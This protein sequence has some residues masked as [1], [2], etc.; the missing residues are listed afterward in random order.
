MDGVADIEEITAEWLSAVLD[1]DVRSVA[2]EAIGT[3]QT[4]ATYRLTLDAD[5]LPPAIV[6]KVAAGDDVAR[7]RVAVGYR[8]EVG[9]YA[10]LLGTVDVR[11]PR[12]WHA[13]V[14]DDATRFTLLLEDLAPRVSGIQ[15]DGCPD[16]R[17][18]D[19]VRNA[20]AL[21]A[22][23]WNDASL[24]DLDF[25]TGPSPE[26]AAFLG[27]VATSATEEFVERYARELA[28]GDKAT[29]RDAAAAMADWGVARQEPF[30]LLHGDY[31][32]DNLMFGADDVV[33]V[34]WQTLAVGPPL[35][36]VAYFLGTSLA[37]DERRRL[38]EDLVGSYHDELR[39][40]GVEGYDA[41]RCFE[42]S[43]LGQLQGPLITTRGAIYA[44][45]ERS[46]AADRMFMAMAS[47]C[48][49]AVRDLR[50]LDLL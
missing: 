6:A 3:G 18:E 27:E 49:A 1:A 35:R 43:R 16:G 40:R 21:H 47:R 24:T 11:A 30:A 34:D 10:H 2:A 41:D 36:D 14:G 29:L 45:A 5:G 12:C 15:A 22:P 17:A 32:L 20:A 44:P 31:R 48:C 25:L 50:S 26:G 28:D 33:A 13:A 42:D 7:S 46:A 9:F 8:N 4:G 19:V 39:A 37:V 23:R 38:E